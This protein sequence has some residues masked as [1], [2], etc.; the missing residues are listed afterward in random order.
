MCFL[1][2]VYFELMRTD[3]IYKQRKFLQ[4]TAMALPVFLVLLI[5]NCFTGFLFHI[6]ANGTYCRGTFFFLTYVFS[7]VY[8]LLACVRAIYFLRD[9][10]YTGNR[11]TLIMFLLF[12]LAPGLA[13]LIQFVNYRLP[14]ACVTM[15]L[16]TLLFYLNWIDQLISLDPLTGLNNRKQLFNSYDH[17]AKN[18]NEADHLYAMM[19]D[20]NK[21]KSINDNY[22]HIQGD[23]ALKNIA[24]ALRIACK[25]LPKRGSIARY[26]GDESAIIFESADPSVASRLKQE[27]K[28][29][30]AMVNKRT[31]IPFEL[32]VSIGIAAADGIMGL[33]ELIDKADEAMYEEKGA[34]RR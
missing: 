32:T 18:H 14:V 25:T 23:N 29:T 34:L 4:S 2:F 9:K 8:V 11:R 17:W 12:P 21:F 1:W 24:E 30:L 22:G 26:G 27:I 19:I 28:D 13:G 31:E 6:D 5:I 7:Y 33:K 10:N 16:T 3:G 20:A 15:A